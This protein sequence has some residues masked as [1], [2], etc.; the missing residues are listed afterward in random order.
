MNENG[1]KLAL[2]E[3]KLHNF[4][5]MFE[6]MKHSSTRAGNMSMVRHLYVRYFQLLSPQGLNSPRRKACTR[7]RR[8]KQIQP[9]SLLPQPVCTHMG[10]GSKGE[11]H[12]ISIP[13]CT[14]A[15]T[16]HAF[17]APLHKQPKPRTPYMPSSAAEDLLRILPLLPAEGE[18]NPLL[19]VVDHDSRGTGPA[20]CHTRDATKL[21]RLRRPTEAWL[22]PAICCT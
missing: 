1:P 12:C 7:G 14:C 11:Q 6:C 4:I 20:C 2:R 18:A 9:W 16:T 8:R 10:Q 17:P 3:P 22:L 19:A 15:R 5:S 13:V 21:S